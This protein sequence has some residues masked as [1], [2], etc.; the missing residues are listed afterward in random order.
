MP[1]ARI[2]AVGSYVPERV[3]TNYDLEKMVDTSDEWIVRR[4]GIR[5]RRITADDEYTSDLCVGAF[6]DLTNHH[7]VDPA[8]IDLI[9]V[10]TQ[11]P[12]YGFPSTAARLQ[13]L[14][15]IPHTAAAFDLSA[16]CA[17]F[18]YG[19]YMA[20]GLVEAGARRK[21]LVIGADTMSKI[22]DY[23]DRTTC[24][25][26]GDG[27]GAVIVEAAERDE[28]F[29]LA[30]GFT[31]DGGGGIHVYRSGL[32]Q[33]MDGQP[34]KG[35]GYTVQNGREVYKWAVTEVS[36]GI[37]SLLQSCGLSEQELDWFIPHGANMRMLESI[38]EKS[39]IS[40]E[41]MLT[42]VDRY[43]N[44]SAA[45]IPLAL[46]PA[47]RDGRIRQGHRVLLYG[48]GAGLVACGLLVRW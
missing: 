5:E 12:D 24:I 30:S 11:T 47:V 17:G 9:I 8:D 43:G 16:A 46:A 20:I 2:T 32:S 4:T 18:T 23:T 15:G 1:F 6:R 48:F 22:T 28:P 10:A 37:A 35:G 44:T 42:C 3:L 31:T 21:A 29:I 34:L 39:R 33:T 19:L 14:L 36:S 13:H 25:L 7:H 26:F 40:A 41:R 27:A 38:C 45:S